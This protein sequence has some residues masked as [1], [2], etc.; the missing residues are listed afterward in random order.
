[1]ERVFCIALDNIDIS[2]KVNGRW[3]NNLR[4]AD[5]TALIADIAKEL[6]TLLDELHDVGVQYG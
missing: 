4:Y 3:I 2:V 6:Q 1:M 5:D